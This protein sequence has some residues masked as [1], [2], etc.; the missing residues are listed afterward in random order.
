MF[1]FFFVQNAQMF[2]FIRSA[3]S[4]D[5]PGIFVRNKKVSD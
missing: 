4:Q 1:F 2:L 5:D 3:K